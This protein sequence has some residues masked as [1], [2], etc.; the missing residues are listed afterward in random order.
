MNNQDVIRKD[1]EIYL[2]GRAILTIII[3]EAV[4]MTELKP[5]IKC[6]KIIKE[7]SKL[8]ATRRYGET[9]TTIFKKIM[10]IKDPK[11]QKDFAFQIF[12][13]FVFLEDIEFLLR[14]IEK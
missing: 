9:A 11:E 6:K 14:N 7:I 5:H 1:N 2:S 12:N 10:Q 8:M 13:T 4:N 3:G